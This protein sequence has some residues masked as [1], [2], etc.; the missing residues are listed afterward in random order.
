VAATGAAA[1]PGPGPLAEKTLESCVSVLSWVVA[2]AV[3]AVLAGCCCCGAASDEPV[4]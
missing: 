1:A 2:V 3:V 4:S